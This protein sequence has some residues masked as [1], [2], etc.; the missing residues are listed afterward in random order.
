MLTLAR[1]LL[2]R[3]YL[4]LLSGEVKPRKIRTALQGFRKQI[5]GSGENQRLEVLCHAYDQAMERINE[6]I[7]GHRELAK[8]VLSWIACAKRPLSTAELQHALSVEL[9]DSTLRVDGLLQIDD[10]VAVC[11]GLVTIDEESNIIRLV[12]YTTQEYFQQ[13]ITQWF[14]DAEKD[15]STICVTYLSFSQFETGPCGTDDAFEQ[16]QQGNPLYDYAARS[17]GHHAR[18]ALISTP[19]I[20]R[21]LSRPA[22][23]EA[24]SQA[25]FAAKRRS[26]QSNYSQ[27]FPKQMTALHAGAYFGVVEVVTELLKL[28]LN[29]DSKDN[30]GQ[31]PLSWAARNGHEA[32]VKLLL[33][34]GAAIESKDT[35]NQTPLSY[36]AQNNHE[37]I[38]QLLL[39]KGA[40]TE[41]KDRYGQTPLS[42]AAQNGHEAIVKLLLGKGAA[43]ESKDTYGQTPLSYAARNH[44]KAIV[45]VLLDKGAATESQGGDGQ[46]PLSWAAQNGHEVIV[47][48]LLDKGAA[49]ESKDTYG[50]K[51]LNYAAQNGHEAIVKLLLDKGAAIESKGMNGWTPLSYAAQ[52]G[53]EAIVKLLLDKGAATEPKSTYGQTPLSL[54]ALNGHDVIVKL[55]QAK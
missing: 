20:I 42:Y 29:A 47:K 9:G 36:A 55:L 34:K 26:G 31:T 38:V 45:Q 8:Q 4:D 6:Q 40:A 37:A 2:A 7:P 24:S 16:R 3:I 17:W 21:F 35:Y 54:A 19:E 39:D 14:P 33:D 27:K 52:N 23:I 43:T 30:A 22:L 49:T 25:L 50:Q 13:T 10:M 51:P 5:V 48:L 12:H 46:T 32:I 11:A 28:E 18:L 41:S 53:H 15:I 1:F 44:D